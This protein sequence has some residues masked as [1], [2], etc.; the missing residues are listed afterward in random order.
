M[1][2]ATA[3]RGLGNVGCFMSGGIACAL[4]LVILNLFAKFGDLGND[5]LITMR[6]KR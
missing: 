2:D 6:R 5:E 1:S 3:A 4:A